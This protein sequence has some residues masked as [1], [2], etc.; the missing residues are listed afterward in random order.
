M[1]SCDALIACRNPPSSAKETM[2]PRVLRVRAAGLAVRVVDALFPRAAHV[3]V[4]SS[5]DLDDNVVAL[6]REVPAP[7][8]VVVLAQDPARARARARALGLV[9]TTIVKRYSARGLW[10]YLRAAVAISTH[11]FFDCRRRAHGKQTVGL[12]H[13]EFGKLIGSFI[14]ERDR[15]FDW[16]PVSSELSRVSRSAEFALSPSHIHVV[17]VPRQKL[18]RPAAEP[19]VPGR[20]VVWVPTYRTSVTGKIRT[21]GDPDSLGHEL[22]LD[23]PGLTA[24]LDRFDA[25]LWFRPHPAAAQELGPAGPRVRR[26]ANDDL[27]EL[28][29]T[30]YELLADADCFVTDYSSVWVDFLL[31]DRPMIAFCPDLEQ[32]RSQRGLALE[33]HDAWFPGPV[34]T[35]RAETLRTLEQALGEPGADSDLRKQRMRMLH[36]TRTDPVLAVWDHVAGVLA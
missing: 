36:T 3:V 16:V 21:D 8:R 30:F 15:H 31:R 11:G 2:T 20:H 13:G 17:G 18:L 10:A 22:P 25:T 33:P 32:Y 1:I 23:D 34:V 19:L 26:A 24:L 7:V 14:G 4:H 35:T 29:V 12:W 27:Q 9:D 5:P 6:L 28:G